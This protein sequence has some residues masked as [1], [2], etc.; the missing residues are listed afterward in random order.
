MKTII[1]SEKPIAGRK[2]AEILSNKNFKENKKG[3]DSF[4]DFQHDTFGDVVLIPLKG[5]ISSVDF[6]KEY[7]NWYKTSLLDLANKVSIIYSEK[8]KNIISILKKETKDADEVI[9]ATDADREGE[10]IGKEA[11]NYILKGNKNIKIKRVYFSAITK[12]ELDKAFSNLKELDYKLADAADTRREIDLIWGAVLT[13]FLSLSTR[14]TGKAFLSV[15]RVQS[16][17]LT[18]I[19]ERQLEIEDFKPVPFWEIEILCKKE[20]ETETFKAKYKKGKFDKLED[21]ENIFKELGNKGKIIKITKRER[22]IKKPVPFNTTDFLRA[23]INIGFDAI[24]AMS[25][26][27]KLYMEGYVSYPRTDNQK[28]IG[29]DIKK[30]LKEIGKGDY[31]SKVKE[32]L[33]QDKIIASQGKE[34]KD[35]PPIHPV[36][37]LPEEKASKE[38]YKIYCLIVDRFLA[39]LAK[40][41]KAY[42]TTVD[43][44]VNKHIFVAKGQIITYKGWM[45]YYKYKIV[46]EETLPDLNENDILD[47]KNKELLAK[48]TKPPAYYSQSSLIKLMEDLNLGTKSTRPNIISKLYARKYISGRKQLVASDLAKSVIKSLKNHASDITKPEMTAKLEEEMN[49]IEKGKLTKDKVVLDSRELLT[50]V[51]KELEKNKLA[52]AKEINNKATEIE[53]FGKCPNCGSPLRKMRSKKGKLFVSCSNFPKCKTSYPL[54]QKSEFT[55]EDEYCDVC[56]S[57][58]ITLK[59]KNGFAKMC[60]NPNCETNKK[61]RSENPKKSFKK[62][63]K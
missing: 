56:K 1:I 8:E 22:S 7:S 26:A 23:A 57:P 15:G 45:K 48:Q 19:V 14:N 3:R 46:K 42:T 41:A 62:K 16:P 21:A 61:W 5:H 27:E 58:K 49:N 63:K 59:T 31:A 55:F 12:E 52:I 25:L 2:I 18:K 13:R 17:T 33:S 28:Y 36:T 24:K 40:D 44:D 38:E 51:L 34:A 37:Y 6:P 20:T 54:P 30:T 4:F 29:V 11:I 60:I 47:I 50:K 9:I 53:T 35:H 32:I 39:T 10:S 43:I